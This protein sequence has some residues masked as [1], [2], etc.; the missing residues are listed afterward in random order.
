MVLEAGLSEHFEVDTAPDGWK[1][2]QRAREWRP[3]VVV[4][5]SLMPGLDGFGLLKGLRE[6]QETAA[7]PVIVLTSEHMPGTAAQGAVRPAAIV[8]KSMDLSPLIQAIRA[9]LVPRS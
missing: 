3:D 1:G 9:A 4:T 6:Y 5:D 2:L 8:A 7:I